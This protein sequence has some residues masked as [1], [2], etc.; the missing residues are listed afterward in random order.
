MPQTFTASSQIDLG[1]PNNTRQP[2]RVRTAAITIV[3][4][5]VSIGFGSGNVTAEAAVTASTTKSFW[6]SPGI[7]VWINIT[8]TA[9]V[10][11][12]D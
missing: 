6:H 2:A 12:S 9:S 5:S 11:V 4:G 1:F 3:S 10:E 7:P 8:G